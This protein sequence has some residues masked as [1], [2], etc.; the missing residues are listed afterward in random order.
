LNH[1]KFSNITQEI[2]TVQTELRSLA[3]TP[4]VPTISALSAK[5]T[6]VIENAATVREKFEQLSE[7]TKNSYSQKLTEVQVALRT[8]LNA[9]NYKIDEIE[10][11]LNN[12]SIN[13]HI[14]MQNAGNVVTSEELDS[15]VANMESQVRQN[16]TDLSVLVSDQVMSSIDTR[17][18]VNQV[19]EDFA[20]TEQI[21]VQ[22]QANSELLYKTMLDSFAQIEQQR[23]GMRSLM[24][25]KDKEIV[26]L[27]Q[28]EL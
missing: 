24:L 6:E 15:I 21:A 9:N 16:L 1:D 28:A 23:D 25:K 27:I 17:A 3:P 18:K 10:K 11:D 20:V 13:Q 8:Q 22:A 5:V 12:F 7:N 19:K 2:A 4:G 26:S 14:L